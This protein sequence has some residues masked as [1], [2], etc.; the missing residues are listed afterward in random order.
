MVAYLAAPPLESSQ[1]NLSLLYILGHL[2][3]QV[4]QEGVTQVSET[5]AQSLWKATLENMSSMS[6][7]CW[8]LSTHQSPGPGPC[9]P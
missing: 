7:V 5:L 6:S 3:D 1:V 2:Q 4:H 9:P 8:N